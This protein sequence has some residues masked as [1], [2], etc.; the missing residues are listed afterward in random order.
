[1]VRRFLSAVLISGGCAISPPAHAGAPGIDQA[2]EDYAHARYVKA[3]AEFRAA[4]EEGDV[5]AQEILGFM[6]AF[7]P[8]VYPGIR[9]DRHEAAV[10]FGRAARAGSESAQYMYCALTR[11]AVTY[12][13]RSAPCSMMSKD[14]GEK[15]GRK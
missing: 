8:D 11:H 15:I 12:K 10:W 13:L 5:R 2:M 3:E 1:M 4:A 14:D 9:Y 6:Y 7:G